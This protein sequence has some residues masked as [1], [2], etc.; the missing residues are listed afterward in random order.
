MRDNI[1]VGMA[2]YKVSTHPAA[3][4]TLGLGSC[5][6]IAL[7]DKDT[8]VVG[9]AHIML[10]SS[11]ISNTVVNVAKFADTAIVNMVDDMVKIGANRNK[12]VAKLAGGAQMF[13]FTANSD[14]VRIGIRN[15]AASKE[16][17]EELKIPILAEDV[18]GNCGRTIE[19]H[20]ED[21]RLMIKTIGFG[22]KHI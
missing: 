13:Q 4:I 2:D 6:G 21:G 1:K 5:V 8:K 14:F 22:E 16:A 7:Y 10:P 15:I 12:I 18:G 11:K 9:L 3:L 19:L 20:S 17:L